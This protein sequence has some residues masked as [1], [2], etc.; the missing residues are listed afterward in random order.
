MSEVKITLAELKDYITEKITVIESLRHEDDWDT[1]DYSTRLEV[2]E[3]I[4]ELLNCL[5]NSSY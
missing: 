3:E 5:H 1:E 2:Y 4:L